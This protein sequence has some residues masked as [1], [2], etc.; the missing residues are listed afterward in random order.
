MTKKTIKSGSARGPYQKDVEDPDQVGLAGIRLRQHR[1]AR[2]WTVEKL[3]EKAGL[4]P[5]TISGIESGKSGY[6][7]ATLEKLAHALDTTVGGLFDIDPRPGKGG[8]T[9]ELYRHASDEQRRKLDEM[10]KILIS[11]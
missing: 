8:A 1:L 11:K 7:P 6:S 4:S 2:A 3:A 9:L 10:A 5:G